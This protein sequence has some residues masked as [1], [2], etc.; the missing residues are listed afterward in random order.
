M[1]GG[2]TESR[3]GTRT[4]LI[5][6][7]TSGDRT[8]LN[9]ADLRSETAVK[10]GAIA[11]KPDREGAK[12]KR[13]NDS[14]NLFPEAHDKGNGALDLGT[15]GDAPLPLEVIVRRCVRE[16]VLAQCSAVDS[17]ALAFLVR[18]AGVMEHLASFRTFLLGL[19]SDFLHDFTLR[20]LDGLYDGGVDWRRSSNLDAAFVASALATGLDSVPLAETFRYEVD[21]TC[22][23]ILGSGPATGSLDLGSRAESSGVTK[24]AVH[25]ATATITTTTTRAELSLSSSLSVQEE[26]LYSP[27]ALSF[28]SP[29]LEVKWPV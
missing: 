21:P 18:D 24:G 10:G 22:G 26:E 25:S 28:V 4:A 16:P 15:D 13:P 20:L 14:W 7:P 2:D 29:V 3:S 9:A 19:T 1:V 17:A 8:D 27:V 12:D 23:G 5:D 11:A 6:P